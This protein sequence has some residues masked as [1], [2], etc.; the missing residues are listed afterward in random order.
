LIVACK[1]NL[2]AGSMVGNTIEPNTVRIVNSI[3]QPTKYSTI[4]NQQQ[5]MG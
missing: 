4:V 3:C 5:M 1:N 2:P